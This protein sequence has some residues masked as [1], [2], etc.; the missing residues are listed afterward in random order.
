[1]KETS[2]LFFIKKISL[3]EKKELG[4]E[5]PLHNLFYNEFIKK[6]STTHLSKKK[7]TMG[8]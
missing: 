1:M 3:R 2:S 5:G 4:N 6:K 7:L 8:R